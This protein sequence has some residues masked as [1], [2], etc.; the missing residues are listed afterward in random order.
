MLAREH[1]FTFDCRLFAKRLFFY[2]E[3]SPFI[4]ECIPY[5]LSFVSC[6]VC[7]S[8]YCENAARLRPKRRGNVVSTSVK[9]YDD[10]Q[11]LIQCCINVLCRLEERLRF[12]FANDFMRDVT[13][14]QD[15]HVYIPFF[16]I[17]CLGSLSET[18]KFQ[19]VCMKARENLFNFVCDI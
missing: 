15:S 16:V 8:C 9:G 13:V 7:Y 1:F 18:W 17:N 4:S 5:N 14:S 19:S 3:L 11:T 12:M 6:F 10:A 2:S